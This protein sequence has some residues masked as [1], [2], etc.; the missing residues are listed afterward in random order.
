MVRLSTTHPTS[1]TAAKIH[2][3]SGT[4]SGRVLAMAVTPLSVTS[5]LCLLE[6]RSARPR[7]VAIIANVAMN[8]TNRP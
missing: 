8:G 1:A 6:I 3:S 2:T 7:A 4:P 5:W